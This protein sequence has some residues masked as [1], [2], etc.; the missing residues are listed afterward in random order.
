MELKK[1]WQIS[2]GSH[3]GMGIVHHPNDVVDM[4]AK[5]SLEKPT[6]HPHH[7]HHHNG[8]GSSE[9]HHHHHLGQVEHLGKNFN[10]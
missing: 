7:P 1:T 3:I 4:D 9:H 8:E 10:S 5:N 2:T 6:H